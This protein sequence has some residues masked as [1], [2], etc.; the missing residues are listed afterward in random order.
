MQR[1][2]GDEEA[3]LLPSLVK[4]QHKVIRLDAV[5]GDAVAKTNYSDLNS[6]P[7]KELLY[8]A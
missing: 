8:N 2:R 6:I 7:Q 5:V 4:P 3:G 1:D